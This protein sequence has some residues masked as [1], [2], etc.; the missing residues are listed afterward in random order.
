MLV[1]TGKENNLKKGALMKD[2]QK[3]LWQTCVLSCKYCLHELEVFTSGLSSFSIY[4][5][6]NLN[7]VVIFPL[8]SIETSQLL[9][10]SKYCGR[11]LF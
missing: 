3:M 4:K 9:T 8:S 10:R 11:K 1:L 6:L 5:F 2:I 7:H